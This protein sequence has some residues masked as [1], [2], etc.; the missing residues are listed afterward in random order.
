[1]DLGVFS[2]CIELIKNFSKETKINLNKWI[3]ARVLKLTIDNCFDCPL[4]F[5]PEAEVKS[6][7]P[8]SC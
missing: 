4:I 6:F 2:C 1:M 7:S 5:F 3:Y 8:A